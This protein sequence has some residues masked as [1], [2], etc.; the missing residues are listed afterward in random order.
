[1]IL[2]EVNLWNFRKFHVLENGN[3]GLQ[4]KFH[5]GLNALIGES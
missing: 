5:K 4:V 1:M 3:P 2:S